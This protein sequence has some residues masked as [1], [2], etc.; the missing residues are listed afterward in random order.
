MRLICRRV[1]LLGSMLI[2]KK[3]TQCN[4]KGS[5]F[6]T[7]RTA[8]GRSNISSRLNISLRVTLLQKANIQKGATYK[9]TFGSIKLYSRFGLCKISNEFCATNESEPQ[10]QKGTKAHPLLDLNYIGEL[11]S[12]INFVNYFQ[13]C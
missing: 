4:Y 9:G 3:N 8:F 5:S 2:S 6:F 12:R 10:S 1:V 7:P 13:L 11:Y